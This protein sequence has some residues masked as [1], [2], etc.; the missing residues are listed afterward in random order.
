MGVVASSDPEQ[1]RPFLRTARPA[2]TE[3][4][5]LPDDDELE[6]EPVDPE[7]LAH[8]RQQ[9]EEKTRRA[10]AAFDID[11]VYREEEH[12]DPFSLDDLRAFRFTTRHL[13][14]VTALLAVVLTTIEL[15][16]GCFGLFLVG[17][18]ALAA[19]WFFVLKKE[20]REG[21]QRQRRREE[22]ER[23]IAA[24]R[25]EAETVDYVP[26]EIVEPEAEP[27]LEPA[28][29]FSFSMKEMLGAMTV[30]SVLFGLVSYF[31]EAI[32][33]T[34]LLGTIA[35]L[36]L[37]VHQLGF[38]P[39]P[40]VVLGWWLLLVLYIVVSIWAVLSPA[41]V[42]WIGNGSGLLMGTVLRL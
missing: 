19:G 26:A 3:N 2:M 6:L 1:H 24:E 36:G 35:L 9:A 13:L 22:K 39:P 40:V 18:V 15:G 4:D 8:E 27:S 42:V 32:N 16:G 10:E 33:A 23:R 30:A 5:P 21:Q 25:G 12:T 14:I 41:S 28:F 37:V 29:K 17:I 34:L 31:G 7:I 38:D 11:E 20:K